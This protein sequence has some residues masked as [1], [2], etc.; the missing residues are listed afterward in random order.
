MSLSKMKYTGRNS[1]AVRWIMQAIIT[2]KKEHIYFFFFYYIPDGIH[3]NCQG[4]ILSYKEY[5]SFCDRKIA[6]QT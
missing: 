1:N 5:P 3:Q 4:Y 2:A 6:K